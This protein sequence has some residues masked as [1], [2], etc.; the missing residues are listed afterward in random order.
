VYQ[1]TRNSSQVTFDASRGV[2]EAIGAEFYRF[3]VDEIV[4][5]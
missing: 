3:E 1:A 4:Q 5:N 2:A